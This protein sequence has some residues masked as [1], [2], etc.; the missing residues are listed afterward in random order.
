M[1]STT[2][3][4]NIL[5]ILLRKHNQAK[6]FL[7]FP[8]E[9]ELLDH[10]QLVFD[11]LILGIFIMLSGGIE[12]PFISVYLITLLLV[13][14]NHSQKISFSIATL[15]SSILWAI[16]LGEI[17][18]V[19]PHLHIDGFHG[20]GNYYDNISALIMLLIIQTSMI[21]LVSYTSFYIGV[22]I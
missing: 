6:G 17:Y 13:G 1:L 14:L 9:L 2:A 10:V 16:G 8:K 19:L 11:V 5:F 20:K 3:V 4:F 21:C 15:A 7:F 22:N 18:K 12:S